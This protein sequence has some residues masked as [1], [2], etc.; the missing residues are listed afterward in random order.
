MIYRKM[1]NLKRIKLI[2]RKVKRKKMVKFNK[3]DTSFKNCKQISKVM[4]KRYR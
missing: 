2:K 4:R 1:N 3:T